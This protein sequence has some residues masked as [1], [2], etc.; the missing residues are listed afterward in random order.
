MAIWARHKVFQLSKGYYGRS[1]NCFRI[2]I[3]RL[4]KALQYQYKSRRLRRREVRTDWI[5][6]INAGVRD[7]DINYSRF[8][9]GLN[10]SN[11]VLDRKI[12]ANLAQYEPYSFKAVVDE[13]R[14][15]VKLPL[16]R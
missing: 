3:R 2:S 14:T 16:I 1:K 4:F 10:R 5:R 8:I 12:L 11:M 7:L 9:Y 6:S 13:V 15:Q